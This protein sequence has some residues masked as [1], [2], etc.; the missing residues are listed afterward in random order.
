MTSLLAVRIMP[1]PIN[2][3]RDLI[4]HPSM[5]IV[6][7]GSS[8]ISSFIQVKIGIRVII[9]TYRTRFYMDEV[10]NLS[11]NLNSSLLI[12]HSN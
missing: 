12:Y 7:E 8:A 5:K 1:R 2:N 3:L 6:I 11:N 4:D 9:C 10:C